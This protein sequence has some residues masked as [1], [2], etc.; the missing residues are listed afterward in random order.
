MA[1]GGYNQRGGSQWSGSGGRRRGGGGG[2]GG[3]GGSQKPFPTEPPYTAFVG[4]LPLSTIQGDIDDIFQNLRVRSVR[5]VRDRETDKFKGYC[6]VE[7]EDAEG[8]RQALGF[9]GAVYGDC[10]LRIDIAEGRRDDG[11]GRGGRGGGRGRGGGGG[12]DSRG[13]GG[14]FDRGGGGGFDRGGG[15][16]SRGGGR[17]GGGEFSGGGGNYRQEHRERNRED[18]IQSVE[19]DR[20]GAYGGSAFGDGGGFDRRRGY[21][22]GGGRE[23]RQYTGPPPEEFKEPDPEDAARRPRLNLKPRSVADPVAAL[24]EGMQRSKLF[25]DAKPREEQEPEQRKLSTASSGTQ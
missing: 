15:F 20:S 19:S 24:A 7:F 14:G 18:S 6:Y 2:G 10:Q 11:G 22:H 5:L 21:G 8:L 3:G 16:E 25:G 17:G 13:S 9:N 23:E 1:E 12:F 4:N